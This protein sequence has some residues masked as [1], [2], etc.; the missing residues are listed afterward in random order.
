MFLNESYPLISSSIEDTITLKL[1]LKLC[2]TT[3]P[4]PCYSFPA[5][6]RPSDRA[7]VRSIY[8][9]EARHHSIRFSHDSLPYPP[10]PADS[11]YPDL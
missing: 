3:Y 8:E 1:R 11:S 10:L 7:F 9:T 4:T 6:T 2:S 5:S